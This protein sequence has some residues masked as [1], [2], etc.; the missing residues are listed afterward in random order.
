MGK[1]HDGVLKIF[2][3]HDQA[4]V[5]VLEELSVVKNQVAEVRKE[6]RGKTDQ[7]ERS[8]AHISRIFASWKEEKA[9]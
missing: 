7:L 2:S 8:V 9:Y 4:D 3:K 1:T 6:N 5:N